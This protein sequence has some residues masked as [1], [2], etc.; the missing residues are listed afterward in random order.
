MAL[1]GN[2]INTSSGL[3]RFLLTAFPIPLT[4]DSNYN[5]N[6][7]NNYQTLT[8]YSEPGTVLNVSPGTVKDF[9]FLCLLIFWCLSRALQIQERPLLPRQANSCGWWA[10]GL[11]HACHVQTHRC[12]N[13]PPLTLLSDLHSPSQY[14]SASHHHLGPGSRQLG[15]TMPRSLLKSHKLANPEWFTLPFPWEPQ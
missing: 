8:A 14:F 4:N 2:K 11:E 3:S 12:R 10:G 13:T 6:N 15:T 5:N 1:F 7:N 9:Y